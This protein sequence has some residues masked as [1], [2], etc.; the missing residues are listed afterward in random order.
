MARIA[1]VATKLKVTLGDKECVTN[2]ARLLMNASQ[3]KIMMLAPCLRSISLGPEDILYTPPGF[4]VC[5]ASGVGAGA[6]AAARQQF[7][8]VPALAPSPTICEMR[9]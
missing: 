6:G 7:Q 3:E 4:L 9:R 2:V 8:D 1:D 5:E